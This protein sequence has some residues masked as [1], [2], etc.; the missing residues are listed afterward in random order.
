MPKDL[1]IVLDHLSSNKKLSNSQLDLLKSYFIKINNIALKISHNNFLFTVKSGVYSSI[2]DFKNTDYQQINIKSSDF[3]IIEKKIKAEPDM[4][5]KFLVWVFE[6]TRD[7]FKEFITDGYIDIYQTAP[8]TELNEKRKKKVQRLVKI[9][10]PLIRVLKTYDAVSLKIF[11]N[12][13]SLFVVSQISQ[14]LPYFKYSNINM[15][16]NEQLISFETKYDKII[17]DAPDAE[18][19]NKAKKAQTIKA[20][21]DIKPKSQK[22]ALEELL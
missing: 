6:Q 21:D 8:I 5:S 19:D 14:K 1:R 12:Q 20:L 17:V 13:M 3:K 2:L 10:S 9:Y 11:F 18:L 16:K 22:E 15:N 4:Y 7:D